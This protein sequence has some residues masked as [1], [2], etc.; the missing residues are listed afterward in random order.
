[1][2]INKHILNILNIFSLLLPLIHCG[3]EI[4]GPYGLRNKF[5]GIYF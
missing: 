2:E 3:I 1:M 4:M 5:R